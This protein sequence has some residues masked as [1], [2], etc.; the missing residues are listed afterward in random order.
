M[1]GN[2]CTCRIITEIPWGSYKA[3]AQT[4]VHARVRPYVG[5][6]LLCVFMCVR[7][8]KAPCVKRICRPGP[9][10]IESGSP[11][12]AGRGNLATQRVSTAAHGQISL[13]PKLT[14]LHTAWECPSVPWWSPIPSTQLTPVAAITTSESGEEILNES[15]VQ[16]WQRSWRMPEIIEIY[17]VS[18]VKRL[19]SVTRMIS[20]Q[21]AHPKTT[22]EQT[23]TWASKAML[24]LGA[25]PPLKAWT[26]TQNAQTRWKK[27]CF[28]SK[29]L[30]SLHPC[31]PHAHL[32]FPP[33]VAK[34][35]CSRGTP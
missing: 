25:K 3:I 23:L 1:I 12:W 26:F 17:G 19:K 33:R 10:L 28:S 2:E 24:A 32:S 11:L 6:V 4:H 18:V 5:C 14:V 29:A 9:A 20:A 15:Q 21:V 30:P 22:P 16:S 31:S 13:T 34:L 8:G 27:H 35:A 7:A